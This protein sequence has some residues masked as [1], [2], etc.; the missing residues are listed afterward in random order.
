VLGGSYHDDP[1]YKERVAKH[2]R[3]KSGL[4]ANYFARSFSGEQY[5]LRAFPVF[6]RALAVEKGSGGLGLTFRALLFL[7]IA[8]YF[9]TSSGRDYFY[10]GEVG[11]FSNLLLW[12]QYSIRNCMVHCLLLQ[13]LGYINALGL[14]S[15]HRTKFVLTMKARAFFQEL[16][17]QF[18]AT[19]LPD[20]SM[21]KSKALH[22]ASSTR[23]QE[24]YLTLG[25]S[26]SS[27]S[28]TSPSATRLNRSASY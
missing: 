2:L 26:S 3:R 23:T 10:A 6:H 4:H 14:E 20:N 16:D 22:R 1:D 5:I 15:V 13:R 12:K 18:K 17:K 25:Q 8:K 21:T 24:L 27:T 19:V 9:L 28:T 11:R 7:T